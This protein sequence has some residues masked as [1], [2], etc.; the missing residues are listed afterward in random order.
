MSLDGVMKP[1]P[2]GNAPRID[3]AAAGVLDVR[4]SSGRTPRNDDP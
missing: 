2:S 4:A 3:A 1:T